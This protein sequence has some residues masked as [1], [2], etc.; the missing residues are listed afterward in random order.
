MG[1]SL[2]NFLNKA[3][4][5]VDDRRHGIR[6]VNVVAAD[7]T[8]RKFARRFGVSFF[9]S[10]GMTELSVPIVGD[11]DSKVEG[12]CGRARDGMEVRLVDANDMEVPVGQVGEI[13]V[14]SAHP[15]V[16]NDGYEANPAATVAAWRNGWFHTGDAASRDAEGNFFFADRIKDVIRRR[17]ENISSIE[18]EREVK[19]LAGVE[20]AAAVAVAS[21][22]GD[23]D[24]LVVVSPMAGADI[25]PEEL[26]ESLRARMPH[27]M[28]PRYIRVLREMPRTPSNKIRKADLRSE[29]VTPDT[30]DREAAGIAIR[31][32]RFGS[33]A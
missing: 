1:P 17:G 21:E 7:D 9:P 18:V 19:A 23:Q 26:I 33:V 30:W 29:G 28:V 16:T 2:L 13:V 12:S 6:L 5:H 24:I 10:F 20:D 4:P 8:A 27:F 3:P 14:R 32:E 22:H 25:V 15:W 31:A 11:V